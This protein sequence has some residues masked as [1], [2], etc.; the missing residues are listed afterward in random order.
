MAFIMAKSVK[1]SRV[2]VILAIVVDWL[3]LLTFPINSHPRL[4]W[5]ATPG[6]RVYSKLA[7]FV[8]ADNLHRVSAPNCAVAPIGA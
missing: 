7:D 1:R 5:A 6:I 8:S 2:Q 4:P 3:Q